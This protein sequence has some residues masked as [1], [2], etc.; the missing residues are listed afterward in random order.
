MFNESCYLLF[1]DRTPLA[2][3][4]RLRGLATGYLVSPEGAGRQRPRCPGPLSR[5]G[6]FMSLEGRGSRARR[7]APLGGFSP[8]DPCRPATPPFYRWCLLAVKGRILFSAGFDARRRLATPL[9]RSP[10]GLCRPVY[11]VKVIREVSFEP[12]P[13]RS[14]RRSGR[15][16]S[17]FPPGEL[18]ASMEASAVPQAVHTTVTEARA[19]PP[20]GRR[21]IAGLRGAHFPRRPRR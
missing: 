17:G 5:R 3:S 9:S 10:A 19:A 15:P 2:E 6:D 12:D 7:C 4:N 8:G 20:Q 16:P 1:K 13:G 21:P 11:P 14:A 18:H